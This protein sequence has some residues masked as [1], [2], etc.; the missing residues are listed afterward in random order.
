MD[1]SSE[2]DVQAFR[3]GGELASAASAASDGKHR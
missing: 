2:I 1:G 3:F